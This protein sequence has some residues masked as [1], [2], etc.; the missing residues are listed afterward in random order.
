MDYG[1]LIRNGKAYLVLVDGSKARNSGKEIDEQALVERIGHWFLPPESFFPR[2]DHVRFDYWRGQACVIVVE[3][4]PDLRAVRWIKDSDEGRHR[5]SF[6]EEAQYEERTLAL[7]YV[8]LVLP[9]FKEVLQKELCQVFYRTAPLESLDD[10]LCM[11]NLLNVAHAYGFT[12]WLC[13][14]GYDQKKGLSL[15]A[16]VEDIVRYFQWSAFNRSAEFH[17]Q[18]S[19]YGTI[20][21]MKLDPRLASA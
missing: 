16:K 6:G 19:H 2:P 18:N 9:F 4:E 17:E 14:V 21:A 13:M 12:S 10:P 1:I 8:A 11:T 20:R 3:L 7:P 5:F 15:K